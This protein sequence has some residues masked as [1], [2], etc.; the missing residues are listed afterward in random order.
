MLKS[1]DELR[2]IDVLP[3]CDV[4]EAKDENGKKIKIPYLNWAKCKELLHENGAEI[5]YFEPLQDTDGSFI[6]KTTE[7]FKDKYN[8]ENQC[9]FVKIK[10]IIDDKEYTM[11]APLLNGTAVV[12]KETINQLRIANAHA[13]AFVKCVAIHTGLGFSLWLKENNEEEVAARIET[14]D[15]EA[16]NLYKIKERIEQKITNKI[17]SGLSQEDVL[18]NIGK[19]ISLKDFKTYMGYFDILNKIDKELNK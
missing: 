8:K 12:N 11:S 16:H 2:K 15:L 1:Y 5:V 10:V 9:Y 18:K 7:T 14:E 17:M 19:G 3:F 13:R 6:F 4:R